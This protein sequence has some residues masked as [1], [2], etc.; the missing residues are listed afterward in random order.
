VVSSD[1]GDMAKQPQAEA[2]KAISLGLGAHLSGL[3]SLYFA[4]VRAKQFLLARARALPVS[5][6][7]KAGRRRLEL[8][9]HGYETEERVYNLGQLSPSD[10]AA[11]F[12]PGAVAVGEFAMSHFT[13]TRTLMFA[14]L[15]TVVAVAPSTST[16]QDAPKK[17]SIWKQMKDAAKQAGQKP[18][19][20]SQ[21]GQQPGSAPAPAGSPVNDS[22]P[23]H[24]P[25]GTKITET[26]LAPLPDRAKFEVSPHGVHVATTETDGS[27][28]VVWHDGVEGPKFDEILNSGH[29]V[30]SPDGNRYAYCAR[31]GDQYV[32]MVDG[33]ELSRGSESQ[34]GKCGGDQSRLAFT[35]NSQH[36]YYFA[37]LH[38]TNPS[39]RN[40]T[41]FV[42]DGKPEIPNGPME[43]VAFSPDGNHYAYI[44]NDVNRQKPWMLIVDGKPAAYQGGSPQWTNDSKHLYTQRSA[45]PNGTELLFDGRPIAKAFNFTVYIPPVGDMVVVAVTGGSTFHPFSFL[46]VNGKK[47]PGSDTVERGAINKVEFSPDGKHY[48]ALCGDLNNRHYLI[49]DGKRGQEYISIDKLTFTADSSTVVY[50][51]YVN[52]KTFVIVGDQE[53]GQPLGAPQP[54][55]SPVGGRVAAI[56]MMNSTPSLLIDKKVTPLNIRGASDLSFSPDG[57]HY[58]YLAVDQGMGQRLVIDGVPQ[59]QSALSGDRIDM[60][61]VSALKYIFS[62]DS[63]H[64]A[65]FANS[66]T[67][68]GIF[69]DGKFIPASQDGTNTNLT[70]SPDSKHLFW[71]HQYGDRPLR[72]FIDGKPLVDFFAAGNSI[73]SVAGW[74]EFGSDSTLSFLAQ[75]DNS[76]KRIKITLSPETGLATM[77]GGG[78]ALAST[79]N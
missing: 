38:I 37:D 61:N 23:F 70:F 43:G 21:P 46:V 57:A 74:W 66:E 79:G 31:S 16:A 34:V 48:A 75:D 52:A 63:K 69:L 62:A 39:D 1:L 22:G 5:A 64:V 2:M 65:H 71:I 53:F 77:S 12:A 25:A 49:V 68:H 33:K 60:Q 3:P 4:A 47:V 29:V 35:S 32:V 41:R 26:V 27:R 54:I 59:P 36:V 58:A 40:Y 17:P 18:G 56:L 19:Q 11:Q 44:W 45:P 51:A 8:K 55:L 9:L 20:P 7:A 76:L 72:V 14:F 6:S 13:V 28:A 24:P 50:A 15:A 73:W 78:T 30:F 10:P 67:A 42:F